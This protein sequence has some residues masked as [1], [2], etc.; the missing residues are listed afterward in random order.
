[1]GLGI[2]QVGHV[3][4]HVT[5]M[6]RSIEFYRK[7]VG[8]KVTGLWGDVVKGRQNC[9]RRSTVRVSTRPTRPS[10]GLVVC[11]ISRS[12]SPNEKNGCMRLIMC[13]AAASNWSTV[14]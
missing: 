12:S 7:V 10:D 8:L 5:D 2:S 9:L 1:M 4:I 11:I 6:D 14:R 13:A 3:G